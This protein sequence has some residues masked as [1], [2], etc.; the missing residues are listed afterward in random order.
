MWPPENTSL[1]VCFNGLCPWAAIKQWS[2]DWNRTSLWDDC[3]KSTVHFDKW[4]KECIPKIACDLP[5]PSTLEERHGCHEWHSAV[6]TASTQ[7]IKPVL[8]SLSQ[9]STAFLDQL[10]QW[11]WVTFHSLQKGIDL[12][13][14]CFMQHPVGRR[15]RVRHLWHSPRMKGVPRHG[16]YGVQ[17]S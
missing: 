16:V 5:G 17:G 13:S 7:R 1:D 10:F 15:F 14:V 2:P 8:G 4:S 3:R 12:L 11:R 9:V 6:A